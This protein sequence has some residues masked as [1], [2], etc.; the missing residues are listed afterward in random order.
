MS[1]RNAGAS[2]SGNTPTI[3]Q[4]SNNS[5]VDSSRIEQAKH[6]LGLQNEAAM[7]FSAGAGCTM[8]AT[9]EAMRKMLS[10]YHEAHDRILALIT[11]LEAENVRLDTA[12]FQ[13]D[14]RLEEIDGRLEALKAENAKLRKVVEAA[15]EWAQDCESDCSDNF[16]ENGGCG[17]CGERPCDLRKALDAL[18]EGDGE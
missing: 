9:D 3:K 14:E 18:K 4:L 17:D 16:D 5:S 13:Q 12:L 1:D 2:T 10:Q 7:W 15:E 6:D 8:K 11:D